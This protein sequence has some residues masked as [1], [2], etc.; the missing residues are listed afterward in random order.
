MIF[1]DNSIRGCGI[2]LKFYEERQRSRDT[3]LNRWMP[4]FILLICLM[5]LN[6]ILLESFYGRAYFPSQQRAIAPQEATPPNVQTESPYVSGTRLGASSSHREPVPFREIVLRAFLLKLS[7]LGS[8]SVWTSTFLVSV[9][10]RP[11]KGEKGMRWFIFP[12]SGARRNSS[13]T[14]RYDSLCE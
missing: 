8:C 2:P 13:D 11:E 4:T 7:H 14:D 5:L 6:S 12:V 10:S 9:L 3:I 1:S